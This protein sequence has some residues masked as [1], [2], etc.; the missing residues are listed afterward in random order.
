[1]EQ[2][3]LQHIEAKQIQKTKLTSGLRLPPHLGELLDVHAVFPGVLG[4][5]LLQVSAAD[6]VLLLL[7]SDGG[8]LLLEES[9]IAGDLLVKRFRDEHSLRSGGLAD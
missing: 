4:G 5:T 3:S 9:G 8:G 1:M 7:L 6:L 2:Q